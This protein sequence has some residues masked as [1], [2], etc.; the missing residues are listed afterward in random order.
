MK[1]EL[2]RKVMT[3]FVVLRVK[4]FSYLIH[5]CNKDEKAKD[6]K[7]S[8]S[9]RKIKFENYKNCVEATQLDNQIK[10]LERN[11]T[12]IYGITRIIKNS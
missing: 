2:G 5:S 6:T 10:Y 8:V 12:G 4:P 9:K 11:K 7:K 3:K 1:D